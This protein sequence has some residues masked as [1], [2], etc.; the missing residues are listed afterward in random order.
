M[1]FGKSGSGN[2]EFH[3]PFELVIDSSD[4]IFV[5]DHDNQRVQVFNREGNY[6]SQFGNEGSISERLQDPIGDIIDLNDNVYV[7]DGTDNDVHA[8]N[9]VK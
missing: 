4:N 7:T 8:F 2:G 3:K 1:K 9:L 6:I 5:V